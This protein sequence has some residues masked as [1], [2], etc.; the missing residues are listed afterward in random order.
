MQVYIQKEASPGNQ[1]LQGVCAAP[2]EIMELLRSVDNT[3]LRKT[4]GFM[5]VFMDFRTIWSIT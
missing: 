4:V 3:D 2:S 1:S 5:S